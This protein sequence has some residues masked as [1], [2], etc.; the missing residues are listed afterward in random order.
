MGAEEEYIDGFYCTFQLKNHILK[1][2]L[3]QKATA[4]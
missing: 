4:D 3:L 2:R 1:I